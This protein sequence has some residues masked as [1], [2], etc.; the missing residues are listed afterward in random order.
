MDIEPVQP[1]GGSAWP[2]IVRRRTG[3]EDAQNRH[4]AF[5]DE[6][7]SDEPVH[8]DDDGQPHIDIRV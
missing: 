7:E 4:G 3:D 6:D 1:L 5:E 8:E 2:K